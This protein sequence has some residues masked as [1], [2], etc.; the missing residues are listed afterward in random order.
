MSWRVYV[1]S[2]EICSP[3]ARKSTGQTA[4]KRRLAYAYLGID[5]KDVNC[6]PFLRTEFRRIAR[7][8][9]SLERDSSLVR[10]LDYLRSSEDPEARKVLSAY[11]SVPESYRKLLPVEAFCRA[12]GVSPQRIL[13]A[14][15]V[16]AVR[17]GAAASAIIAA[18]VHPRVVQKTVERALR[19]DGAE[20]RMVLHRAVGF[21][22][23]RT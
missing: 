2:R 15:T 8:I 7:H 6:F 19:D 14:I 10:P 3:E 4:Y 12:A 1:D 9:R 22:S 17:Q 11:L 13:E 21:L 20:E 16:V 18:I 23:D 5:P